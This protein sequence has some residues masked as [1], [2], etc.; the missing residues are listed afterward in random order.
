MSSVTAENGIL[1]YELNEKMV[2]YKTV[3]I[4][5]LN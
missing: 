4:L 5:R 2:C 1:I 3:K